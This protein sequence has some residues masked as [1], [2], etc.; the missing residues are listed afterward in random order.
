M[1]SLQDR[2]LDRLRVATGPRAFQSLYG[3]LAPFYDRISSFFFAGQWSVW[4]RYALDFIEGR[5]VLELGYGTGE[6]ALEMCRRG[7]VLTGVDASPRMWLIATSKLERCGCS[8]RL[9][10]GSATA[11]PLPDTAVDAVVSTFPSSYIADSRTWAEAHRV[12]R[13]AGR[14]VVVLSG[15]LL[16][17]DHR[18]KLLIRFHRLVYGSQH[19]PAG[20]GWPDVPGFRISHHTRGNSRG[21]AYILVAEKEPST[22]SEEA[23]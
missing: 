1:R 14:L 2:L 11:L 22:I 7:Y 13:P 8:A 4:Q 6:L 19:S 10:V 5:E 17:V 12:L 15:E 20:V 18:S 21:T 9:T 23:P 16:P 3:T